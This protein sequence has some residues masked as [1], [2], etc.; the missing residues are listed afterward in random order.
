MQTQSSEFHKFIE[1][2]FRLE[3]RSAIYVPQRSTEA[4]GY[5]QP[6]LQAL[7]K[8]THKNLTKT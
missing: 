1:F 2:E 6:S 7:T 5:N 4:V 3:F 8:V